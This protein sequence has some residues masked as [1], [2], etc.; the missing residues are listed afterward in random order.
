MERARVYNHVGQ[1]VPSPQSVVSLIH[2]PSTHDQQSEVH[3]EVLGDTTVVPAS[4]FWKP[5]APT[6]CAERP[7]HLP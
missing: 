5:L 4:E 6:V 1:V 7:H 3:Q 2:T